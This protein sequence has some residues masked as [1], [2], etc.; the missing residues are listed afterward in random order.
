MD[1]AELVR[2]RVLADG[3]VDVPPV[4]KDLL[5]SVNTSVASENTIK[6][7]SRKVS[8]YTITV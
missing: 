3:F 6:E 2:F 8:P 1:I 4:E 5:L 7:F